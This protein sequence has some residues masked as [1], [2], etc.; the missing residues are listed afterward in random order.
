MKKIFNALT[1]ITCLLI[2][3]ALP[4][5]SLQADDDSDYARMLKQRGDILPLEQVIESAMAV[6][7]G[8]ILET[9]LDEEDGRYIYELE[10]LD[11]RGQVWELELDASTAELIELESED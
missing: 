2:L 3:V 10:I 1:G 11:D 8:Q 7:S 6:K 4:G 9:E 5:Q